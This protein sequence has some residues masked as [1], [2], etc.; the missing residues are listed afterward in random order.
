[1]SFVAYLTNLR[2]RKAAALLRETDL[3]S[4]QIGERVGI[5]DPHYFS[6]V[7]KKMTG[8]SVSEYREQ[9]AQEWKKADV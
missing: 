9:I 7:F 2:I 3:R 4:Y 6:H 1:M 8:M 5:P